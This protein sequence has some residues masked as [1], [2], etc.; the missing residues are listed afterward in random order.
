MEDPMHRVVRLTGPLALAGLVC[1]G[2]TFGAQ[3]RTT[4]ALVKTTRAQILVDGRGMTLYVFALDKKNV[5]MCDGK[6][7]VYWPPVMVPTGTVPTKMSGIS[8]TFGTTK[9]KNGTRQL[10]FDGAPLYT[11]VGDKKP[12]DM[13]G[14]GSTGSGGYWWVVVAP[15]A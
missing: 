3:A 13:T 15:R 8:G 4:A 14:Q 11:Y 6:C 5:S 10:T 2:S 9:R 1:F 12:G 7:A